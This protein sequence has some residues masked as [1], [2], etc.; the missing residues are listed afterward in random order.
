M[1]KERGKFTL[2]WLTW[3]L[4]DLTSHLHEPHIRILISVCMW[5]HINGVLPFRTQKAVMCGICQVWR[6]QY[7]CLVADI[8]ACGVGRP[9]TQRALQCDCL[10]TWVVE[11]PPKSWFQGNFLVSG[12]VMPQKRYEAGPLPP[13]LLSTNAWVSCL[14]GQQTLMDHLPCVCCCVRLCRFRSGPD[15]HGPWH[16]WSWPSSRTQQNSVIWWLSY[17]LFSLSPGF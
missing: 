9:C 6:C 13:P 12:G 1:W 3:G 15:R 17:L 7:L 14:D 10:C 2:S 11:R 8:T 16:A 5:K 4:K